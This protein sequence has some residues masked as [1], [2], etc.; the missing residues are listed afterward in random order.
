MLPG[1]VPTGGC[2]YEWGNGPAW[3]C[4]C[5]YL[6][7]YVY[8]FTEDTEIIKENVSFIMRYLCYISSRRDERGLIAVGLGD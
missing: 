2:G 4:V 3:D 6:P 7:Y 1:I 8:K 5:M